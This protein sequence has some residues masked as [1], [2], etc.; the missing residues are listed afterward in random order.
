MVKYRF[1][2]ESVKQLQEH[3]YVEYASAEVVRFTAEFKQLAY[4]QYVGGKNMREIFEQAGFDVEMLGSKRLANFRAAL[5]REFDRTGRFTDMR[6]KRERQEPS[7]EAQLARRIRELE[8]T[9]TYLSQENAFL[10]KIS[11]AQQASGAKGKGRK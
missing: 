11:E 4:D 3:P 9:V 6:A 2:P 1:S 10:K 5:M 7:T 8:H